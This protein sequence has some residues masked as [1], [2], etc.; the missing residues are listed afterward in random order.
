MGAEGVNGAPAA[1]ALARAERAA[2]PADPPFHPGEAYP[3]YPFAG[4]ISARPNP[5]YAAVREAFRLMGLDAGRFGT[6]S[7]NPLSELI[8]P[9]GTVVLKPNMVRHRGEREGEPEAFLTHG[10]IVRAVLDYAVLALGGTG[11]IT[12]ADAPQFDADFDLTARITGIDRVVRFFEEDPGI[13]VELLD[14][15]VEQ[16]IMRDEIIVERRRLAGDP[17]GYAAVSLGGDSEFGRAPYDLAA[18]RGSDADIEKT[19]EHHAGDR[20]E[21]L[22]SKTVLEADLLIDLPKMKT[23]RK[24]GV[25][26]CLKNLIGANGDKNWIPHY[27]IGSPGRGGDEFPTG[28]W[29]RHRESLLK[30]RVKRALLEAGPAAKFLIGKARLIQKAVVDHTGLAAI[31]AGGWYGNDTLWRSILDLAR[32]CRYADRSGAMRDEPQ[33][34]VLCLVDGIVAGEG[35][36]PFENTPVPAGVI[37]AGTDLVAVDIAAVD[38]MGYDYRAIPKI[39]RALEPHR[40]PLS[41][42]APG[43]I[44]YRSNVPAWESGLRRGD[45]RPEPFRPPLG[46]EG[47]LERTPRGGGE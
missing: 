19:L 24:S 39:A 11:R 31:R 16:A 38:L 47:R 13:P 14:L 21:Y 34:T 26:L 3:E 17:R 40:W 36:G 6:P 9:G 4:R 10:S 45:V 18:L 8:G 41:S 5:A 33:R 46:W 20:H 30:E 37:V 23:H 27:R 44:D 29:L 25:T 22:L 35:T 43:E 1:V 2:Y 12:V 15:R 42:C 28:S 32:A 7:W